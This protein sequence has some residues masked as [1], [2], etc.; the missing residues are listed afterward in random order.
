MNS[1]SLTN[2]LIMEILSRLPAESVVRF[3]C[4]SKRWASMFGTPYFKELCRT[5]NTLQRVEI[6]GF[7]EAVT[8]P[9]SVC[10]FVNHG[11]NHNVNDLEQLKSVHPPLVEPEY[12][13]SDSDSESD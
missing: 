4:V 1:Y 12:H 5:R 6:Q 11:E 2:D 13:Q 10:T 7:G 9:C 8:K 3:C